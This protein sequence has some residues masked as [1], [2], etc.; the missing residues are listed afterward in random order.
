MIITQLI[1]IVF[2]YI[3]MI[4]I[5]IY[6][7]ICS[8]IYRKCIFKQLLSNFQSYNEEYDHTKLRYHECVQAI[9]RSLGLTSH[10]SPSVVRYN[11]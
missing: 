9:Y 10:G 11:D 5:N 3:H 6:I 2:I 4:H 8:D 7:Y 1:I